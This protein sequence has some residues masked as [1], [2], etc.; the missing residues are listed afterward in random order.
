VDVKSL[1]TKEKKG[2]SYR[3]FFVSSKGK[4]TTGNGYELNPMKTIQYAI[5]KSRNGDTILVEKG[6][7]KENVIFKGKAI[8]LASRFVISGNKQFIDSTIIDGNTAGCVIRIINNEGDGTEVCGLVIQNGYSNEGAGINTSIYNGK[9]KIKNLIFKS[10]TAAGAGGGV[11]AFNRKLWVEN[12]IF[13]YNK[14]SRGAAIYLESSAS[15]ADTARIVN[16]EFYANNSSSI[17][18]IGRTSHTTFVN[19][20]LIH[21]EKG[22]YTFMVQDNVW[23][24]NTTIVNNIPDIKGPVLYME[25]GS[26]NFNNC[27]IRNPNGKEFESL[28]SSTP[29]SI[30]LT[31]CNIRGGYTGTGNFDEDPSFIPNSFFL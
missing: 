11:F 16:C 6:L 20:C 15:T 30:K 9:L 10:N 24:N 21:D 22:Q 17:N 28:V 1:F 14:A 13:Y 18:F 4:D 2:R 29:G 19:N 8:I 27:I 26:A 12:C 7:Y 3:L 23:F 31:N 25:S 5:D